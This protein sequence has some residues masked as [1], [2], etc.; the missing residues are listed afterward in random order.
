M[1]E[2]KFKCS[3]YKKLGENSQS[4]L[5]EAPKNA[6]WQIFCEKN[7]NA[8]SWYLRSCVKLVT[9]PQ[10]QSSKKRREM[11]KTMNMR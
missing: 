9:S 11:A 4:R 10:I 5:K 1:K 6:I 8:K 3:T 2:K 7:N